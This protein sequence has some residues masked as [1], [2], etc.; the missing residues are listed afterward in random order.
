[1]QARRPHPDSVIKHFR[2]GVPRLYKGLTGYFRCNRTSHNRVST[3]GG[4]KKGKENQEDFCKE[5]YMSEKSC[6]FVPK[7]LDSYETLWIISYHSVVGYESAGSDVVHIQFA[8]SPV[9]R[10]REPLST[11][12]I[13]G[14]VQNIAIVLVG[15]GRPSARGRSR[16]LPDCERL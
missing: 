14:F 11:R 6:I 7:Y 8:G 4:C 3:R 9:Q 5:R 15:T 10:G 1:M 13:Y 12:A 2:R 16:F